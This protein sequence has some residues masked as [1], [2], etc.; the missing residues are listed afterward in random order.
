MYKRTYE[1]FSIPCI[2]DKYSYLHH[3][4]VTLDAITCQFQQLFYLRQHQTSCI[5]RLF[6][7]PR[8]LKELFASSCK[9]FLRDRTT[10]YHTADTS[11]TNDTIDNHIFSNRVFYYATI[12]I[13]ISPTSNNQHFLGVSGTGEAGFAISGFLEIKTYH[14]DK[15]SMNPLKH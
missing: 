7:I 11:A 4:A 8:I 6:L 2:Y 3:V 13:T 9:R 10:L 1:G 5:T 15:K 14:C 12:Y